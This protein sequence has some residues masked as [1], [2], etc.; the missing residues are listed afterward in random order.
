[1]GWQNPFF[2]PPREKL[3]IS[4]TKRDSLHRIRSLKISLL[5]VRQARLNH[6]RIGEKRYKLYKLINKTLDKYMETLTQIEKVQEEI[7]TLV[8]IINQE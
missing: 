5:L 8:A 3:K 4:L 7:E 2:D 6:M 1:M